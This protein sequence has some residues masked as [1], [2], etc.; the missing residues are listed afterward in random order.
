MAEVTA[1]ERYRFAPQLY[2]MQD[3]LPQ[4]G[5][6]QALAAAVA[7]EQLTFMQTEPSTTQELSALQEA[8]LAP[9][10][11]LAVMEESSYQAVQSVI[12]VLSLEP[13]KKIDHLP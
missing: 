9:V 4:Q 8:L 13:N 6:N 11:T 1:E 2:R 7:A 12:R 10:R 3:L 5:P